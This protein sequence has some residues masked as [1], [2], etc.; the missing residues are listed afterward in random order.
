MNK[1]V[2]GFHGKKGSGKNFVA[3]VVKK[4]LDEKSWDSPSAVEM[5]AFADPIKRFAIDVLGLDE[6]AVY[7]NDDDKNAETPYCWESMP[8]YVR[9]ANGKHTGPMTI[10]HV[11]QVFGTELNREVWKR[12]IWVDAAKNQIDGS[13]RRFFLITDVR[14]QNEIDAVKSWGGYVWKVEGNRR[15]QSQGDQHA[16]EKAIDSTTGHDILITNNVDDTIETLTIKVK[17][18]LAKIRF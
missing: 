1:V 18:A 5:L 12:S 6:K 3:D 9:S 17:N 16:S 2:I 7:G 11:L 4:V 15:I 14:F 13:D 10:R 8:E